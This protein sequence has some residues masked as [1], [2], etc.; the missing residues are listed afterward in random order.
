MA[1]DASDG[2]PLP[3]PS[4]KVITSSR[5]GRV[6]TLELSGHGDCVVKPPPFCRGGGD[7]GWGGGGGEG[8]GSDFSGSG[9]GS[10]LYGPYFR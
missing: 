5:V 7:E 6:R 10:G 9:S 4:A 2:G 3:S 1:C 8:K